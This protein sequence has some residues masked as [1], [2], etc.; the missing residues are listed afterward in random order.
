M[1]KNKVPIGMSS[2]SYEKQKQLDWVKRPEQAVMC[3]ALQN[4]GPTT[5]IKIIIAKEIRR[6]LF[7]PV[8][9]RH[10]ILLKIRRTVLGSGTRNTPL[11]RLEVDDGAEGITEETERVSRGEAGFRDRGFGIW[12]SG[13]ER[14]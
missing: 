6:N 4:T 12:S 10:K 7:L 8:P 14:G 2:V 5:E 11:R 1:Y 9:A 13:E 3:C